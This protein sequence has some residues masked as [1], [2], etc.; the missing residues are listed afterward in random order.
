ME[1]II[2]V[3]KGERFGFDITTI[4]GESV[5]FTGEVAYVFEGMG[6]GVKFV[7]L[8]DESRKFLQKIIA[9]KS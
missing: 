3:Q 8:N 4:D 2:Q 5:R 1:S 6:F 9:E 7:D